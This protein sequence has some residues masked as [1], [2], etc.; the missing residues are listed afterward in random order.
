MARAFQNNH[1]DIGERVMQEKPWFTID[2]PY[3]V[4]GIVV[5]FFNQQI[6]LTP[7]DVCYLLCEID[8]LAT[9]LTI[10]LEIIPFEL[11]GHNFEVTDMQWLKFIDFFSSVVVQA[12]WNSDCCEPPKKWLEDLIRNQ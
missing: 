9:H 11:Y 2:S 10:P 8:V 3:T 6:N 5:T 12:G 7:K 1:I 4:N